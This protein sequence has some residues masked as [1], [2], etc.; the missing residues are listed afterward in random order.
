MIT[1]CVIADETWNSEDQNGRN[2]S[3]PTL[4]ENVTS[5]ISCVDLRNLNRLYVYPASTISLSMDFNQIVDD[6]IEILS[7]REFTSFWFLM[8]CIQR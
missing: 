3:L 2:S 1:A 4:L 6:L 5:A 8:P 7:L